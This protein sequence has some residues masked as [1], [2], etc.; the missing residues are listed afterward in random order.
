MQL[1]DQQGNQVE[2]PEEQV[3]DAFLSGNYGFADAAQRVPVKLGNGEV[4]TVPA[5]NFADALKAGA[6][7]V[8]EAEHRAA[9]VEARYGGL[10]GGAKALGVGVLR[11]LSVG[12]SDAAITAVAPE[13][14]EALEG[15]KEAHPY[16]SGAGEIGGAVLPALLSGGASVPEE[17]AALGAAEGAGTLTRAAEAGRAALGYTP[18]GLM[19]RAGLAADAV[20]GGAAKSILGE[21]AARS[22]IGR[23][24]TQAVKAGTAGA[25]E[26]AIF[27]GGQ[28]VSDSVLHN[29]PVSIEKLIGA[30]GHGAIYGAL[31]GGGLGGGGAVAS[32]AAA[33]LL[34]KAA[35]YIDKLAG[36]QAWKALS[37]LK[38][39]TQ[40]AEA[41]AGGAANVGRTLL[42]EGVIPDSAA[43]AALTPEE[44]LPRIDVALKR[45]GAELGKITGRTGATVAL[46]EVEERLDKVIAPLY[47]KAL[48]EP[49]V[50][51]LEKAKQ[52]VLAHLA[53]EGGE[54]GEI[55]LS[56][57]MT[58]RQAVED[59]AYV[60]QKALDPGFRVKYLRQM[61]GEL[62][63]LEIKA[64]DRASRKAGQGA[65]GQELKALR[66][67]YQRLSIAKK[68]AADSVSRMSTNRTFSLSDVIY[69][70]GGMSAGTH[71]L[72]AGHPVGAAMGLATPFVHKFVRER[73]NALAA[74]VLSR[75]ARS[76]LVV[77][78]SQQVD[79]EI[80][81][82]AAAAIR[83]EKPRI[84]VRRFER[85]P[86][87][88]EPDERRKKTEAAVSRPVPTVDDI[89]RSLPQLSRAQAA[90]MQKTLAA[91]AAIAA[92]HQPKPLAMPSIGDLG[93]GPRY[94]E[95]DVHLHADVVRAI[96]D[97][98]GT[99]VKVVQ[100]Q[101]V[102]PAAIQAV[103][104]GFPNLSADAAQIALSQVTK[105]KKKLP[106]ATVL[107]L[108]KLM[109]RGADPTLDPRFVDAIQKSYAPMPPAKV[110]QP[111]QNPSKI[112]GYEESVQ[113]G[114]RHGER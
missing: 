10:G 85:V 42:K 96:D 69:G 19:S 25:V 86:E 59:L 23:I 4:G 89:Q 114:R 31:L 58:Q 77:R 12:L 40:E 56:A 99:I 44:L 75:I 9:V 15:L 76:D 57:L 98:V 35:P 50:D 27:G 22:A 92:M 106:Y 78:A 8:S 36:T 3:P 53:A 62:A 101:S 24:A 34:R 113:L 45:K 82:A 67:E 60:E 14:R 64:I 100:G 20:A 104:Q 6:L 48:H 1:I 7:P 41:R 13:A 11:G 73:G 102:S 72:F 66:T 74:S 55:P 63:D 54:A 37:P 49:I 83:G 79:R 28:Y 17:A 107:S 30:M 68:A 111:K 43:S 65:V 97:P 95:A 70:A 46:K 61:R 80:S 71:A 88:G 51:S 112:Q 84:R 52:S 39:Y 93:A 26:T 94:A 81:E 29:D 2:V 103:R 110:A 87:N 105:R 21:A 109:G 33:P 108:S 38:K 90:T 18:A 32:E 91:T 16:V 47:G 5:G